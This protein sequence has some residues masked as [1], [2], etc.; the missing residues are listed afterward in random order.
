LLEVEEMTRIQ[1][2]KFGFRE[3]KVHLKKGSGDY[4]ADFLL[5]KEY[6]RV[7][8]QAKRYKGNVPIKAIQ[9]VVASKAH[10]QAD[11][12]CSITNSYFTGP[13]RELAK[14]NGVSESN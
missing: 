10:Y 13:A 6:K 2:E 3:Y 5:E 9:E 4:G 8:V 7:V 14:S 12:F 1:F 11:E